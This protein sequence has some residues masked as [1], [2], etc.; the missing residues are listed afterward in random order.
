MPKRKKVTPAPR[1]LA[2]GTSPE[3][4]ALAEEIAAMLPEPLT[5]AEELAFNLLVKKVAD[6]LAL[7]REIAASGISSTNR[8]TGA[9]VLTPEA[10]REASVFAEVV[11]LC[12]EFGLTPLSRAKLAAKSAKEPAPVSPVFGGFISADPGKADEK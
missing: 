9:Q 8:Y 1:L 2:I 3:E 12:R 6:W 11:Q 5:L 7:N 4:K 10:R